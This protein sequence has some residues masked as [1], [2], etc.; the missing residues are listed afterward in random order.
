MWQALL[1]AL[2]P[3]A[4]R[5]VSAGRVEKS[6][7]RSSKERLW[8]QKPRTPVL[9]SPRHVDRLRP[10]LFQTRP[11]PASAQTSFI[12]FLRSVLSP[13]ARLARADFL[14]ILRA[15]QR[16]LICRGVFAGARALR[17]EWTQITQRSSSSVF[18]CVHLWLMAF[19]RLLELFHDLPQ[20]RRI[21]D[22]SLRHAR[23][24]A[25]PSASPRKLR[26]QPLP[27]VDSRIRRGRQQYRRRI[28]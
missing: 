25:A 17:R 18:I 7:G 4:P 13:K 2:L 19:V 12:S 23:R 22:A 10:K 27:R 16:A 6:S 15:F 9:Q 20:Q 3:A 24:P 5:L 26:F 8:R 28:G 21:R 14:A 11:C 1:P